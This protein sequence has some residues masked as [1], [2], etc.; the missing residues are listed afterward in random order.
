[1]KILDKVSQLLPS[2]IFALALLI[3]SSCAINEKKS[4]YPDPL[5]A[6]WKGKSVCSVIEENEEIRVLKCVFPPQVGH[7]WHYHEP[8]V[9]YTLA[10]GTFRISDSNGDREVDVPTGYTFKNDEL[11]E[12][13][14][15]NIGETTA[16]FL[17][18]EYK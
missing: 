5:Q 8:H 18:I 14:V 15:L 2:F 16:E 13:A 1:M 10:G 11:T 7:E 9:G 4:E 12:H 3:I 17:I 6:G